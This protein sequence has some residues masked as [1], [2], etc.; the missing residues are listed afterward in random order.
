MSV[1]LGIM[2]GTSI[3]GVDYALCEVSEDTIVLRKHWQVKFPRKLRQRLQAAAANRSTTYELGQL[4]HDLGRFY[5]EHATGVLSP[6][7]ELV[8][9]HGQTVLHNAEGRATLQ[10]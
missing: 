4:H 2:S 3:D 9:L 8:G 5:A 7:A 10:I 1:V 6:K